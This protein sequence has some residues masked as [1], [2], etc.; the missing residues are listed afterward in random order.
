M[1]RRD[2]EGEERKEAKAVM[3]SPDSFA[4]V[5]GEAWVARARRG[6]DGLANTLE[7]KTLVR[8]ETRGAGVAVLVVKSR[9]LEVKAAREGSTTLRPPIF[10]AGRSDMTM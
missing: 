8:G 2:D 1:V 7:G 3:S 4:Y 6:A 9:E 5:C 10:A